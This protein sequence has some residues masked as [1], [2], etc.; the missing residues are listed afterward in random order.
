MLKKKKKKVKFLFEG[1]APHQA[2]SAHVYLKPTQKPLSS[3]VGACRLAATI[4][5]ETIAKRL[6]CLTFPPY[7]LLLLT[8][9]DRPQ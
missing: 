2:H 4:C 7:P 5:S 3:L 1:K 8:L 6:N 9:T